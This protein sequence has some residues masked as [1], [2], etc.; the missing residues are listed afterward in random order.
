MIIEIPS[1]IKQMTTILKANGFEA[2]LVG[3]CV[4]DTLLGKTPSDFD[5]ATNAVPEEITECF[6]NFRVIPTGIRHGTV[7]VINGTSAA[8]ITTYR[9][10]GPYTLHR[11]PQSVAFSKKLEDDLCRRDFTI[12][13]LAYS[14]DEG[15]IDLFGGISDLKSKII[16]CIGN[17]EKRFEEDALRIMRA[18]RFSSVLDFRI[19]KNTSDNIHGMKELLNYI[20]PERISSELIKL[21]CGVSCRSILMDYSDV[22]AVFIPE[23]LPCIH[24]DQ[25][26]KYHKYDVW[27]HIATAV[28]SSVNDPVIR[29]TMLLHDIKK[30]ECFCLDEKGQGHFYKHEHYSSL[31]ASEILKR[32][33][34]SNDFIDRVC[35]LIEHH[36]FTPSAE[37]KP[38]KRLLSKI[39][40]EAFFQLL[41]VQR[42]DA[43]A[44]N[45]FCLKR[46]K[47]L[48]ETEKNAHRIINENQCFSLKKLAVNGNDLK[49][50]GYTG[51][52]IGLAL[53]MLLNAVIDDK[54]ENTKQGLED[55]L[56][57]QNI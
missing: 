12:N 34:F 22:I 25:H 40:E 37:Y 26:S 51:Q 33:R 21:L 45:D 43:G 8:E 47:I 41:N 7:T 16:K 10:D 19:E 50:L 2:Y 52:N 15:I 13:S 55:Y 6:K 39:G 31:A 30:P 54:T 36:Y 14:D 49:N 9:E 57:K 24:F 5:I 32:L 23:I 44:K 18:V 29:M 17:P 1:D 38:V 48:D 53:E 11:R 4:R 3:G 46:L 56:K 35:L 20:S 42:A 28:E 27:E